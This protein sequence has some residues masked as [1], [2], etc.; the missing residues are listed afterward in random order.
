M[1]TARCVLCCVCSSSSSSSAFSLS[2]A[3]F[4]CIYSFPYI[5]AGSYA[6][7]LLCFACTVNIV[8][9][10]QLGAFLCSYLSLSLAPSASLRL[11]LVS[12]A[13]LCVACQCAVP[14]LFVHDS[15]GA[16][17]FY[18]MYVYS[19]FSFCCCCCFVPF[20]SFA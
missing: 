4:L 12:R 17:L 9:C 7:Q 13:A 11:H 20:H 19:L 1:C 6:I 15:L 8:F 2:S 14:E 3:I 5:S 16:F 10:V 18:V